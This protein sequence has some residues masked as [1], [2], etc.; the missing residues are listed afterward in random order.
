MRFR[1][2]AILAALLVVV[3]LVSYFAGV[4]GPEREKPAEK[5]EK[6]VKEKETLLVEP[7][8]EKI[9]KLRV[10]RRGR[11]YLVFEKTEDNQWRIVEPIEARAVNWQVSQLA[12]MVKELKV[13]DS[14]VPGKGDYADMDLAKLGLDEPVVKITAWGDD[15]R[16]QLLAG[17]NVLAS[18]DTYEKLEGKDQVYVDDQNVRNKVK[19]DLNEYHDKQL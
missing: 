10:E 7:P 6:P 9:D 13:L 11:G 5:G 3:L 12:R 4:F 8:L 18:E 2:P 17:K 15:R 1:T 19:R 14:F 16:V